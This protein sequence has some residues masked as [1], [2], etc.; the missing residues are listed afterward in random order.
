LSSTDQRD[1]LKNLQ[2]VTKVGGPNSLG[3]LVLKSWRGRIPRVP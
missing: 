1:V 3:P 2:Q